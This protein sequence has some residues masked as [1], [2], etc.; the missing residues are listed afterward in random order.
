MMGPNC[1][2]C[3]PREAWNKSFF[4]SGTFVAKIFRLSADHLCW[5]S[6]WMESVVNPTAFFMCWVRLLC[7]HQSF[8]R[9]ICSDRS[10]KMTVGW[11][12]HPGGRTLTGSYKRSENVVLLV[13]CL[14]LLR[15]N[16]F[17]N[18]SL[19]SQTGIALFNVN[20]DICIYVII[21]KHFL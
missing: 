3:T 1:S 20:M 18:Q 9:A 8:M 21:G 2:H 7:C 17:I 13:P 6:T 15:E 4:Y 12:E 14:L 11:Y 19:G 10:Y 16:S 5:Y